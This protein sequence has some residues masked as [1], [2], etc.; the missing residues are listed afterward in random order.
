MTRYFLRTLPARVRQAPLPSALAILGVALGVAAV[1]AVQLVQDNAVAAFRAGVEA[2]SGPADLQV[3]GRAPTFPETLYPAVLAEPGVAAAWPVYRVQVTVEGRDGLVLEVAGVDLLEPGRPWPWRGDPPDPAAVLAEPGWVAVSPDLAARAGWHVG[4][5]IPVSSGSRR[6]LLRVG[7]LVDF[8]SRQPQ[9]S[10]RLA[11]MDLAGAQSLLGQPGELHLVDVRAVPGTPLDRLATRLEARL[12]PAVR[13]VTPAARE[14]EARDLLAAFRLNLTALSLVSV[15]VGLFLVHESVHASLL[16]RR[17]ELGVLRALG[18]TRGQVLALLLAGDV[19]VL[20]VLGSALGV[21]L[22]I[23]VARVAL[24]AVSA[25]L[26]NLYLLE[27]IEALRVEPRGPLLAA[28][29][30][31]G[32]VAAGGVGPALEASRRQVR[33]LLAPAGREAEW[34]RR[35]PHLALVG[36]GV[37]VAAGT[38]Y[39]VGGRSWSPAGFVLG[40]AL[41][42]A[43]PLLTPLL[44]R[45]AG[46]R[47]PVR[48]LGPGESLR[49]LATR[50]RRA[51]FPVAALAIAVGLLTGVTVMVESFRRTL[52]AWVDATVQADVYVTPASGGRAR[53]EATLEPALV[54]AL[55]RQPGVARVDRLRRLHLS[56][57]SRRVAVSGIDLG[58][59]DAGRRLPLAAGHPEE[60]LRQARQEGAVLVS[61]P[62]ARKAG[63]RVGDRLTLPGPRGPRAFPVAGIFYD[64]A[65]EAGAVVMDLATLADHVG[66]GE[67][68]GVALYLEPGL[69]PERAVEA[70]RRRFRDAPLQFRSHRR[71]REEIFRLFDQTFAVTRLLEAITLLVAVAGVALA[72]VALGRER[73][74]ELALYRALG[75]SR[76]QVA[77]FVLGQG[78]ALAILALGLGLPAGSA[79]AAILIFEVNPAYF[80]WTLQVH[81]PGLAL[82]LEAAVVLG[83]ALAASLYPALAASRVPVTTLSRDD[84]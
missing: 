9:A 39:G 62:L 84:L 4:D 27:A 70:L 40:L 77:A 82:A 3:V 48:G 47:I 19:A 28:A 17:V 6:A 35:A 26:T 33:E 25:T 81:W 65:S 63:L 30:G 78:G 12:G 69:D 50:V 42:V 22:G 23:G 49:S 79:L 58:L 7:A 1:A 56:V 74:G 60:A 10:S 13:V 51:A 46:R 20:G 8:R 16:R 32:G 76:R 80:G 72:L 83:A 45:E 53:P 24:G 64:Y 21:L 71:L 73:A 54:E 31:L 61:E 11:L 2:L 43:V 67:V 55:A 38:W 52:A 15:V 37:L 44:V 57:G 66:P 14:A 29:V 59:P 68:Q 41:L 18:A 36:L 5:R 34:A 75:A